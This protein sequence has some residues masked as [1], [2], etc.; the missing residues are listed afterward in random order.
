MR[1]R[2]SLTI[3]P[4]N[5]DKFAEMCGMHKYSVILD[6]IIENT[7]GI[8][9]LSEN[10]F[11]LDLGPETFTKIRHLCRQKGVTVSGLLTELVKEAGE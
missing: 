8:G 4:V 5:F 1:R 3:K 9:R 7:T 2:L 10:A 11:L 6:K